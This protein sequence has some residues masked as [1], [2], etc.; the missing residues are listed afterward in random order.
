M[1]T[2]L[3]MVSG[4]LKSAIAA[5]R[6]SQGAD[7]ILLHI[8]YGQS[9]AKAERTALRGLVSAFPRARGVGIELPYVIGL[10]RQASSAAQDA[11]MT[12]GEGAPAKLSALSIRG[13]MPVMM[14]SAM[15]CAGRFGAHTI[16]CGL[17]EES[18]GKTPLLNFAEGQPG[19]LRELVH[20]FNMMAETSLPEKNAVQLEAPLVDLSYADALRLGARLSVPFERTWSCEAGRS[21]ACMNC[22]SCQARLK[23][24]SD[25]RLSDPL[26]D[27]GSATRT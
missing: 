17:S 1:S 15:H 20:T 6:S 19:R 7:I 22:Y 18:G 16:T 4:G 13:L 9:T 12:T 26:M 8:D 3:A 14:S 23:A 2:T 25:A 11:A 21:S 5:M 24:F 10:D 27:A